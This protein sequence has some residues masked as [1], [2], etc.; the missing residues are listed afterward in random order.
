MNNLYVM[1]GCPGSGKSTYVKNMI[2]NNPSI[3]WISRDEIRFSLVNE[4]EPYFSKE[5]EVFED[6]TYKIDDY[7]E[8]NYDV[9]ADA[10]HLNPKSRAKLFNALD[11]D[12]TKT[13]IIGIVMRTPLD[14]CLRRNEL[15]KGTRGYVPV[16]A[17][18]RM[19]E[20]F[21]EPTFEEY[22]NIFDEIRYIK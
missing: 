18:R 5:K 14:E 13:R 17:V 21:E 3:I 10:T 22:N 15:R 2:K 12:K 20:S 19:F 16:D 8:G 9:V 1:I 7:L 6:F 11:I 4:N